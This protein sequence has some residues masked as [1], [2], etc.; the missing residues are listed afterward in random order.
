MR[1]ALVVVLPRELSSMSG[2]SF[3]SSSLASW[4]VRGM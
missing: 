3:L 4:E 2:Y 1:L